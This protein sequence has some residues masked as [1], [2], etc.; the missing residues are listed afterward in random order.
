MDKNRVASSVETGLKFGNGV[1]SVEKIN[2]EEI[3]YSEDLACVDCSISL[4]ELEPR[5]FSFNTPFGACKKCTGLGFSLEVDPQLLIRDPNI[6]LAENSMSV[7]DDA[8]IVLRWDKNNFNS[9]IEEL[10]V[11]KN[12]PIK[13][14]SLIHISEHTRPY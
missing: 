13:D 7:I 4:S 3:I 9:I 11:D 1:I 5:S 6:S 2:D 8:R 10:D 12:K 14:L